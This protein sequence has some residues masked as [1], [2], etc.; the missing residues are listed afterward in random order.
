MKPFSR[1]PSRPAPV[2]FLSCILTLS[3]VDVLP[4]DLLA[5]LRRSSRLGHYPA[6]VGLQRPGGGPPCV[7][8]R[9][10]SAGCGAANRTD[11]HPHHDR[12]GAVVDAR[13]RGGGGAR[14]PRAAPRAAPRG[15]RAAW[16][17]HGRVLRAGVRRGVRPSDCWHER[18]R[19]AR[20]GPR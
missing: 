16:G 18:R 7:D 3:P 11:L 2:A 17:L 10:A 15:R 4:R 20:D 1:S 19:P 12:G 5:P 14:A 13:L 8:R 6:R 9:A